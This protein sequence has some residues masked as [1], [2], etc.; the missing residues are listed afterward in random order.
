MYDREWLKGYVAEARYLRSLIVMADLYHKSA[1][2]AEGGH[3]VGVKDV[4]AERPLW[5]WSYGKNNVKLT[6]MHWAHVHMPTMGNR[7]L[8]M[9]D[10]L[11]DSVGC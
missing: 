5:G 11:L 8:G 3:L 6:I 4:M 9:V 1:I 10:A 7:Q 2:Y